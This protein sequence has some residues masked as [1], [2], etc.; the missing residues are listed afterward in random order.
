MA[1]VALSITASVTLDGTGAGTAKVGPL[2]AAETWHPSNVHVAVATNTLEATCQ[3]Y[4]GDS[5][6]QRNFRDG[7]FSGSSGDT[8]DAVNADTVKCGHSVYAVWK[9]GDAF[10]N[11]TLTVT[12][13]KDI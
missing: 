4:V 9:G 11:A 2:T 12:G 6:D 1:T 8:S 13:T 5:T 7:S 3:I 10:A